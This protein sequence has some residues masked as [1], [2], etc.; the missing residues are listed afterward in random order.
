MVVPRLEQ[1]TGRVRALLPAIIPGVVAV[2]YA[3]T[4][5]WVRA[6][7]L[8][9]VVFVVAGLAI[10]GV[11]VDH[12]ILRVGRF[13]GSSVLFVGSALV[14]CV[15]AIIGIVARLLRRDVLRSGRLG[16][17]RTTRWTPIV[18]DSAVA[19]SRRPFA[20]DGRGRTM[21]TSPSG[22]LVRGIPRFLGVVVLL[23]AINLGLGLGW[24]AI[25]ARP[26]PPP[27]AGDV[28]NYTGHESTFHDPRADLPA[29]ANAPW[30]DEL[31]RQS[32][33]TPVSYWPF[34]ESRPRKFHSSYVNIDGWDRRSYVPPGA[35]PESVP[36]IWMFGG[37]TTW[38]EGQRDE[39]TIPSFIAR[40]SADEGR[41]VIVRNFGQRGWTHFQEMILF[42][43]L[44]ESEP[45]PDLAVFYD[46]A[47]EINAQSLGIRGVPTHL[48]AAQY[49]DLL[50]G[51][52][53]QEFL[54][55]PTRPNPIAAAWGAYAEHSAAHKLAH[56][57]GRIVSPDA[58]ASVAAGVTP[59]QGTN[60]EVTMKDAEAAVD[61]YRRGRAITRFLAAEHAVEPVF[62]WQPVRGG[63]VADFAAEQIDAPTI[64]IYDALDDDL[65]VYIDGGHHNERGAKIVA[66]HVLD[67][68][69]PDLERLSS[70]GHRSSNPHSSVPVSTS[71]TTTTIDPADKA[72]PSIVAAR[73]ML[74]AAAVDSCKL[75]DLGTT[76]GQ[77]KAP[78]PNQ[79]L[80]VRALAQQY[81]A[82][83]IDR[84]A[85]EQPATAATLHSIS[86]AI[87]AIDP[88]RR[89]DESTPFLP[90]VPDAVAPESVKAISATE[91]LLEAACGVPAT[92][93]APGQ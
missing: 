23:L 64:N 40:L 6:G 34:T 1:M 15:L 37:S 43:Q 51:G 57:I 74:A 69:R 91:A 44:L 92:T 45:L 24:E 19:L 83:L 54:T 56:W 25:W 30:A 47:N 49:A 21:S 88:N 8:A 81:L 75:V 90:Q 38:G 33:S 58:G 36:V 29:M 5:H 84:V 28:L 42:E 79:M 9:V 46:G 76:L 26:E 35:N 86:Q 70:R 78:S 3:A 71:S 61:V 93:A 52:I 7:A 4:G 62:F 63:D 31:F 41:P 82:L 59:G 87:A 50:S 65:D 72:A 18:D 10:A 67:S 14:G 27:V 89:F 73:T 39:E 12:H 22:V 2:I 13:V 77:L 66:R 11:P 53:G 68:I 20:A 32:Q 85:T 17:G 48:L 80:E 55:T 60:Y 16:R